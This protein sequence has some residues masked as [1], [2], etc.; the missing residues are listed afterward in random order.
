MYTTSYES[1]ILIV[2][3]AH[4]YLDDRSGY[5]THIRDFRELLAQEREQTF[6]LVLLGD[7]F[8]FWYE[9][10]HVIPKRAFG[11]LQ[12]FQEMVRDGIEI[13]YFAGNHD[14]RLKGFLDEVVGCHIHM[15]EWCPVIDGKRYYFHHGDG[16][17]KTDVGYRR[18]KRIL[19]NPCMQFLFQRCVHPDLAMS[20]GKLASIAGR[21]KHNGSR[22]SDR[23]YL[24]AAEQLLERGRDLV[25]FGHNHQAKLEE[26][27]GGW[28]HNP[29]PFFEERRYSTIAG[30][31]P[32]CKVFTR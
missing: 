1:R 23:E 19:R 7:L 21:A 6:L 4:L 24:A 12:D 22:P 18:L 15:D 13:H 30:G 5:E 25:V 29:G 14:F 28:Y 27:P 9:W 8:D 32:E 31:L 20:L 3:D 2:A 26:I 17:A 16:F 11:I 10:N